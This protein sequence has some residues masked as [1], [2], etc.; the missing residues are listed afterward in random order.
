MGLRRTKMTEEAKP[1]VKAHADLLKEL[2]KKYA[3][4]LEKIKEEIKK[5]K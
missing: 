2:D 3:A 1:Q 5:I 4:M